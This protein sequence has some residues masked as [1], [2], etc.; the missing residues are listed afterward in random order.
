MVEVD[1]RRWMLYPRPDGSGS[2]TVAL[3]T[4]RGE[5]EPG[6]ELLLPLMPGERFPWVWWTRFCQAT[7]P[8]P[9]PPPGAA[10]P[11]AC[12]SAHGQRHCTDPTDMRKRR[13]DDDVGNRPAGIRDGRGGPNRVR[14]ALY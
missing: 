7:D 6:S 2:W 12:S 3:P 1:G 11:A 5:P 14:N 4:P 10:L 9:A 13:T 8:L